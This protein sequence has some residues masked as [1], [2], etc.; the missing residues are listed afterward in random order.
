P[1]GLIRPITIN[2]CGLVLERFCTGLPPSFR[3]GGLI[4]GFLRESLSLP[5]LQDVAPMIIRHLITDHLTTQP[6]TIG[7]LAQA[8]KFEPQTV[9]GCLRRLGQDD[10]SLVRPL[11]QSQEIWEISHDFLVPLLDSVVAH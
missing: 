4:R 5:E 11:D 6:R 7:E 1:K 2:L 10:R 3:P 8:T 9:R